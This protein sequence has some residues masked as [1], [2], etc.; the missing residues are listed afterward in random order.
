MEIREGYIKFKNYQTYYRIV[1]P[2]GKKTPLLLCHGG[3]GSTHNAF[4]ALDS[5][6]LEDDRPLIMYDQIGCGLSSSAPGHLELWNK[7]TWVDELIN[8]RKELHLDHL[9]LLGHSWGGMLAII[10][11]CDH[12]PDGIHSATL[13]STLSSVNLWRQETHRLLSLMDKEDQQI[14]SQAEKCLDFSSSAFKEANERY[15]HRHIGG[16]FIL[17]KDL[18]CLTRKKQ[19]G[20]ESYLHA[21]GPCEFSP[22]GTLK[23][24]EYT[25]KLA[26]IRCPVLLCSGVDDES[27]PYQNKVMYDALTCQ[28]QWHLFPKSRHMSYVEET[29]E[30]IRV[31]KRFLNEND[32]IE[33]ESDNED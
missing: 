1:N 26:Q 5:L 9:H 27:T 17:G 10:Y 25:E 22:S 16:P 24:Y 30:Y 2:N 31:L 29:D 23:D 7:N 18:E 21:W 13:S 6:A 19:P 14:I 15:Y 3:P 28:K 20:T 8:L 32:R 33:K 12:N 11:L 4:E